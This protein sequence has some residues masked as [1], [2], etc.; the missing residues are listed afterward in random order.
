MPATREPTN[1]LG[2]CDARSVSGERRPDLVLLCETEEKRRFVVLDAKYK[3][4]RSRLLEAMGAAHVYRDGL[5]W[6]GQ[7][8]DRSLLL[9]PAS[10]GVTWL[11]DG[12]FQEVHRVG[13]KVFDNN[14]DIRLGEIIQDLAR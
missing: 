3:C 13:I 9:V 2:S 6:L 7:S 5:R 12:E 14:E 11:E 4:S 1:R 10:E 8:P